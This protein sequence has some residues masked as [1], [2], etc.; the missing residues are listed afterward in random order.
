M[1]ETSSKSFV[2]QIVVILITAVIT[3]IAN[4]F[5]FKSNKQAEAQ[6]NLRNDLLREQYSKINRI[7]NFS[8]R[9]RLARV[10]RITDYFTEDEKT[11]KLVKIEDENLKGI[12]TI[13]TLVPI[14][15]SSE[16]ERTAFEKEWD[17][18]L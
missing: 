15:L 12:D 7:L 6:I 8:Y 14:F 4:Q 16:K 10:M 3:T 2:N 9:F 1:S 13:E 11:G 5:F 18:I 17:A